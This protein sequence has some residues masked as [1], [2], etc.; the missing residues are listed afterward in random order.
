MPCDFSKGNYYYC[1]K[2]FPK[3]TEILKKTFWDSWNQLYGKE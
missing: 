1:N 2:E 3:T